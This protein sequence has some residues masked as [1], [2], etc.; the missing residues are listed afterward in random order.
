MHISPIRFVALFIGLVALPLTTADSADHRTCR[1]LIT[2]DDGI[3]SPGLLAAA[4]ELAKQCEVVVSAPATNQS[5]MSHAVIN[6]GRGTRVTETVLGENI[7]AYAVEGSPAEAAAIGIF[8]FGHDHP[9]DLVVS[10]I[11]TG[12]NTGLKN[13]YSG[14]VNAAM[15][16]AVRNIPAIAVSQAG[17]YGTD[18]SYS[19]SFTKRVVALILTKGLPKGVILNINVPPPPVKGVA[20]LA[21]AGDTTVLEGFD[22]TPEKAGVTV[23]KPRLKS[24]NAVAEPGD[25]Q[26]Y[27]AGMITIAPLL[28]D[29][30][31]YGS[32]D[33]LRAWTITP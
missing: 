13:L 24:V 32:I 22:A 26:S 6:L 1:I 11:N 19:A 21:S 14:T 28:L 3:T 20:V 8:I 18:Y 9:F 5:G 29:R 4:Q 30:T 23:Y 16:A 31:A 25:A 33:M 12:H 2:N 10:G 15:E 17:S 27:Q 7:R